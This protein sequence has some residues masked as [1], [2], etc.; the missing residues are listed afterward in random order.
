MCLS[1][2][3]VFAFVC[4]SVKLIFSAVFSISTWFLLFSIIFNLKFFIYFLNF[5]VLKIN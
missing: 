5:S 2:P 4:E 3:S 1:Q